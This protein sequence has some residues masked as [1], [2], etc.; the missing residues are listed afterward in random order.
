MVPNT[1]SSIEV[2]AARIAS[3]NL[4]ASVGLKTSAAKSLLEMI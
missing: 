4:P 2:E 3:L 1:T